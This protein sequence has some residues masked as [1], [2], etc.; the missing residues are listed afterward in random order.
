MTQRKH[1]DS[2]RLGIRFVLQCLAL[3]GLC[4]EWATKSEQA[5]YSNQIPYRTLHATQMPT[6]MSESH[7]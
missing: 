7:C 5:S 2:S 1:Q 3:V 4:I 6:W